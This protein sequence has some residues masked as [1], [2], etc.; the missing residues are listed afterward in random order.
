MTQQEIDEAMIK[1]GYRKHDGTTESGCRC[2]GFHF[3]IPGITSYVPP[4]EVEQVLREAG[5]WRTE[6][7]KPATL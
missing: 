5:L 7:K 1:L 3:D 2:G 6:T 4:D